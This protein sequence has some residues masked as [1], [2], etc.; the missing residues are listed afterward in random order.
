MMQK[1]RGLGRGLDA[2]L[3]DAATVTVTAE[4][5]S[6][7]QHLPVAFLRRGRFQPR[8][9]IDPERL[10]DL[11]QSIRAQGVIQPIVVRRIE[12]N[13]YE[14]LAGERRWR[15]SQLAGLHEVPVIVKDIDDRSALALALIEN[16]QREE[17]TP[18]ETSE[19]LRRLMEEF[20]MTHQQ[21]AD[22]VGKSRSS[23]TNLLRLNDLQTP[24]KNWLN[25][26]RL[27]MGH[28]RALLALVG[29]E[30]VAAAQWIIEHE[31]T[32]REAEALVKDFPPSKKLSIPPAVDPDTL[33]LQE[34]LTHKLGLP[35]TI[36]HRQN[37]KG[38]LVIAYHSLDDLSG[39]LAWFG[40]D[41]EEEG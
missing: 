27:E 21:I 18:L 14:I 38:K 12:E 3:G 33:R 30:Q 36:Q 2:L 39:V 13:Q 29:D 6:R 4:E 7:V 8:R 34:R 23:I 40:G 16:I 32:V 28:A 37:G 19:A 10:Q 15:A 22:A 1:K 5:S 26:G 9:D 17:L 11:A 41:S 31:L 20:G 35:V 25:E 24:V